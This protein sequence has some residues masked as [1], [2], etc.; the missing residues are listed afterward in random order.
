VNVPCEAEGY[1][2]PII[3]WKRLDST[4]EVVFYDNKLLIISANIKDSGNYECTAKN[5]EGDIL[6][7]VVSVS[8]IGKTCRIKR[9]RQV[10]G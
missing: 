4:N 1:P 8:V 2:D 9:L 7:K 6:T 3:S 10:F 5:A